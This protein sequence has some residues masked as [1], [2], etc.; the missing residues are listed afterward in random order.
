MLPIVRRHGFLSC[1]LWILQTFAFLNI[2]SPP[3]FRR[4]AASIHCWFVDFVVRGS[5][6]IRHASTNIRRSEGKPVRHQC[7]TIKSINPRCLPSFF[8][9]SQLEIK[10]RWSGPIRRY[11]VRERDNTPYYVLSDPRGEKSANLQRN[12]G[13]GEHGLSNLSLSVNWVCGSY[14]W[15]AV[16][17]TRGVRLPFEVFSR[18]MGSSEPDRMQELCLLGSNKY[19]KRERKQYIYECENWGKRSPD[20]RKYFRRVKA[21][22]KYDK[23]K[24][25]QRFPTEQVVKVGVVHYLL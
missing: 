13:F 25:G 16:L 1:C 5:A 11:Q 9:T 24:R 21:S 22:G 15:A 20:I 23:Y 10:R 18:P 14:V 4:A 17:S 19:N 7:K 2:F 8:L 12:S 3:G 6:S